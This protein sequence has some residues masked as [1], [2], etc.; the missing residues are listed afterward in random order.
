MENFSRILLLWNENYSRWH[1]KLTDHP[2]REKR[3]FLFIR[4]FEITNALG[5]IIAV[6][7]EYFI[8]NKDEDVFKLYKTKEGNWYDFHGFNSVDNYYF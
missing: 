2:W 4:T 3:I 8:I 6:L 5:V 1:Q 7:D